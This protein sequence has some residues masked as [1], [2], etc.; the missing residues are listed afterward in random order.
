MRARRRR[1]SL[2]SYCRR[3]HHALPRP[4]PLAVAAGAS[5][6]R[7]PAQPGTPMTRTTASSPPSRRCRYPPPRAHRRC[8]AA[9]HG[10]AATSRPMPAQAAADAAAALRQHG[11]SRGANQTGRREAWQL[12]RQVPRRAQASPLLSK[13]PPHRSTCQ[14]SR[15]P[16]PCPAAALR[17]R[18]ASRQVRWRRS[19]HAMP[20][21]QRL[22]SPAAANHCAL[23]AHRRSSPLGARGAAAPRA[24][25]QQLPLHPPALF[26][27]GTAAGA[28]PPRACRCQSACCPRCTAPPRARRRFRT[29]CPWAAPRPTDPM[30]TPAARPRRRARLATPASWQR[31]C[32]G[33]AP[34]AAQA[35][36]SAAPRTP[37]RDAHSCA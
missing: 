9:A 27:R 33:C 1:H 23:P 13:K 30:C 14:P 29:R 26:V 22:A 19:Q 28:P 4:P 11:R 37:R 36:D 24:G 5:A 25:A 17:G 31:L 10:P 12:P 34:A 16:R 32:R 2:R 35:S 6:Q 18:P 8:T 20:S 15:A 21:P 3:K 7:R